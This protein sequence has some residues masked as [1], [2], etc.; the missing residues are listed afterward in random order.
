MWGIKKRIPLGRELTW[1]EGDDNLEILATKI[2]QKQDAIPGHT[3][4]TAE[5]KQLIQQ[6]NDEGLDGGRPD[7]F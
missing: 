3:L 1:Q 7:S 5:E 2:Q 6:L 4:V